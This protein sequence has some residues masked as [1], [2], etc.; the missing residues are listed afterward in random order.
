MKRGLLLFLSM[1]AVSH[2]FAQTV[3]YSIVAVPEESGIELTQI[4]MDNDYLCLP[5]VKRSRTNLSWL[6]NRIINLS[7]DGSKIAFLSFRNNTS[8]IFIKDLNNQ[9]GAVQR[10]NRQHVL[11][12]TYSPD[13]KN[14]VFSEKRG[15]DVQIFLTDAN[16]GFVCRQITSG[17]KDYSPIYS[18]DMSVVF[19]AREENNGVSIWSYDMQN[20]F[21]STYSSGMNP[22]SVPN[23]SA[24]YCARPNSNGRTEIWKIDYSS[25]VEECIVSSPEKAFSTPM[26][27]PDGE[28]ILMVGESLIQ[29]ISF[30]YRNT[31]IYVCKTD[32]TQLTQLTY[33]AAD[34]LSPIWSKDGQSIYFVSQRGSSAGTANIWKMKFNHK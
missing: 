10:T 12:F 3:D 2:I 25:G 22:Y 23:S 11:D 20:G 9:S 17:A 28:W 7:I 27:S 33:H 15:D 13:G 29:E 26:L 1:C 34:D 21:L 16:K 30:S 6:S 14:I 5:E 19:F 32:G 8:N 31:D 18:F 24:Y 4:T